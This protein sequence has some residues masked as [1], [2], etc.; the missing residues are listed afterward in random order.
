MN[1]INKNV[2][3][4]ENSHKTRHLSYHHKIES[5]V[6]KSKI[7]LTILV[8]FQPIIRIVLRILNW[9]KVVRKQVEDCVDEI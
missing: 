6:L 1:G 2:I 7:K 5:T 3:C 4:I 9:F 8:K